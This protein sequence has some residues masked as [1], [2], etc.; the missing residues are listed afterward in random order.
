VLKLQSFLMHVCAGSTGY[1]ITYF[2]PTILR[3]IGYSATYAQVMSIPIYITA[4]C[5]T[6]VIAQISDRLQHRY[7]FL[8]LGVALGILGFTLLLAPGVSFGVKY[9]ALYFA[10]VGFYIQIMMVIVWTNNNFAGHYKRA[11]AS[12]LSTGMG[13][14]AGFITSNV[15]RS[16][17][18][19][20]FVKGYSVNLAL[21]IILGALGMIFFIG[22]RVSNRRRKAGKLNGRLQ[23]A[24]ADNL[25]DAHPKFR[26]TF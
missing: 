26:Y 23:R 3:G 16:S 4:A 8:L 1:A 6:L 2:T 12:A 22:L 21:C 19:P 5:F 25:G 9:M 10:A 13:N 24:D 14:A 7:G 18:G 15:Y 11:I 20:R 17:D